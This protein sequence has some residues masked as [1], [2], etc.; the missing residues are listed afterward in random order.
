MGQYYY[1]IIIV[2]DQDK[3]EQ[4]PRIVVCMN[5]HDYD[6]GLKLTEHAYM[7]NNF[8]QTFEF[9]LS[10]DGYHHKSRVVWAGDYADPEECGE[11]LHS[12]CMEYSLIRPAIKST[13]QYKFLVNHTKKLYV[14]KSRV[15][16]VD[17]LQLHP[18]PLLTVE[19][20]GRGGGDYHS[21]SP[22]IGSWARDVISVERQRPIDFEEIV[23]DLEAE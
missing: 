4:N 18:L 13:Y 17:G 23:F 12:Q 10:P 5:A 8:V 16:R 22:L 20:N 14:D 9:G 1:P 19:G 3:P 6:N 21:S 7:D 2:Q 15:P 11:T